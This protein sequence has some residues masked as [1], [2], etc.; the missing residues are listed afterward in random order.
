MSKRKVLGKGLS[1]LIPG[2]KPGVSA[3]PSES[4][5]PL[6]APGRGVAEIDTAEIEPNPHQPRTAFDPQA[7]DELA[8]S[9]KEKGIV[10]PLTVRKF[11]SGYQLIAGERRLRAAKLAGM[12]SVPAVLLP[13][14]TDEEAMEIS[15]IENIQREDLTAI[16][17]AMAYHTL[18]DVCR[19][20][21]EELAGKVGKDRSTIAN[22]VR[23]L[24][25]S[26]EVREAL[27]NDRISMGHARALL[28]IPDP[29]LQADL[30]RKIVARGL[31]VRK[32]E[33]LIAAL[34]KDHSPI[35]KLPAKTPDILAVE[36]DLQRRLGTAVNVVQKG[37]RGKIEIEFYSDDDLE[38]LLDILQ[39]SFL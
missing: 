8:R 15:L 28:G 22:M 23:L 33:A 1:A 34:Q 32:T 16:E 24:K 11:G 30:C 14:T 29:K 36:E 7:L 38:R 19:L 12:K 2:A 39:S 20:S 37:H 13:V 5:D 31:S 6:G 4:P 35:Q 17:E 9:I 18:M 21:Q 27:D 3:L 26:P 10:Q 25:L